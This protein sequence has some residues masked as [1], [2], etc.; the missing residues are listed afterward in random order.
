[1]SRT[2]V[3]STTIAPGLPRA[4]LSYQASRSAVMCP[5]SVARHGTMAGTQ[6][7]CSRVIDPISTGLKSFAFAARARS[8]HG[9]GRGSYLTRSGGRHISRH[10]QLHG[11]VVS[12]RLSYRA[13]LPL[14]F[15]QASVTGT[16]PSGIDWASVDRPRRRTTHRHEASD[17]GR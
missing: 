4:N 5:S 2:P 6:V 8:G 14:V 7:R 12:T 1:M 3:A 11:T 9:P 16:W 13:I 17:S 15:R 10:R